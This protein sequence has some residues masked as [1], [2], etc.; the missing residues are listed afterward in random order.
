MSAHEIQSEI[1]MLG[2]LDVDQLDNVLNIA[3]NMA[4]RLAFET[5]QKMKNLPIKIKSER[6]KITKNFVKRKALIK[7]YM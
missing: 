3:D 5:T 4:I 1:D 7:R 2:Y 6:E